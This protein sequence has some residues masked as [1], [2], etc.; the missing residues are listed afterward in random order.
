MS[1]TKG[2][3]ARNNKGGYKMSGKFIVAIYDIT[4]NGDGHTTGEKRCAVKTF[5]DKTTA[6]KLARRINLDRYYEGDD[7]SHGRKMHAAVYD[8]DGDDDAFTQRC[9]VWTTVPGLGQ[10]LPSVDQW[11]ARND[12]Q[13]HEVT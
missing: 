5:N 1:Y 13:T 7:F 10:K 6:L 4:D 3:S 8:H 2:N 12:D 11:D 9:S